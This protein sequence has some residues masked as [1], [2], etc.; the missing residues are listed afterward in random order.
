VS[1]IQLRVSWGADYKGDLVV[2]L[3]TDV[4]FEDKSFVFNESAE[5]AS[6]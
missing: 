3:A 5:A 1:A 6:G 4:I 2:S